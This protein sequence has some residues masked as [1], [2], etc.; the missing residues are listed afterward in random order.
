MK[1]KKKKKRRRRRRKDAEEQGKYGRSNTAIVKNVTCQD[2]WQIQKCRL[3]VCDVPRDD[4]TGIKAEDERTVYGCGLETDAHR[5]LETATHQWHQPSSRVTV[6]RLLLCP[7]TTTSL[8]LCWHLIC[9][10]AQHS[11]RNLGNLSRKQPQITVSPNTRRNLTAEHQLLLKGS[12]TKCRWICI[13]KI[14][15]LLYGASVCS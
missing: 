2:K 4:K 9:I 6:F 14:G 12:E 7:F 11:A 10:V 13:S 3:R 1:K 8:L 15:A 5:H